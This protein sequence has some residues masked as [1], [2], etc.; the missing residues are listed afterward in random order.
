L[1]LNSGQAFNLGPALSAILPRL[2]ANY[3]TEILTFIRQRD[4]YK[5][6]LFE[7]LYDNASQQLLD[8]VIV[9]LSPQ[10]MEYL[11]SKHVETLVLRCN[12][13]QLR[14]LAQKANHIDKR[15]PQ[16]ILIMA[17][18]RADECDEKQLLLEIL[19][20]AEP[21]HERLSALIG[22]LPHLPT[23]LRHVAHEYVID[24]LSELGGGK[25]KL[26]VLMRLIAVLPLELV[27]Q[28]ADDI[29]RVVQLVDR[30]SSMLAAIDLENPRSHGANHVDIDIRL[31]LV[32]RFSG[33]TR[34]GKCVEFLKWMVSEGV[35]TH[36]RMAALQKLA[37]IWRSVG[38]E[39]FDPTLIDIDRELDHC[40]SMG[41]STVLDAFVALIPYL[42]HMYPK[43]NVGSATCASIGY[44]AL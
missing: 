13:Q 9:Q 15:D 26:E 29:D 35:N 16:M 37:A 28:V 10:D 43:G 7:V 30:G 31:A 4:T 41:R 23:A 22:I 5:E 11:H 2:E 42:V 18:L 33:R 25:L 34:A 24:A 39:L 8:A 32:E 21:A 14:I 44:R 36:D 12:R 20:H 38:F 3:A 27:T 17:L 40:V 6:Q 1:L 19:N